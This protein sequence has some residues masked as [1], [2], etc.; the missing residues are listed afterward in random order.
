MPSEDS[1]E[2]NIYTVACEKSWRV[3]LSM[4]RVEMHGDDVGELIHLDVK[5]LEDVNSDT[6]CDT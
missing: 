2:V 4:M 5:V 6:I 3:K 1:E